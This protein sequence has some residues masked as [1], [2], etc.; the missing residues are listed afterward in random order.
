MPRWFLIAE[1]V[2]V[3]ALS[4][5]RS[6]VDAVVDLL[7]ALAKGPLGSQQA[8]LNSSQDSDPWFDLLQQLIGIAFTLVPVVL[9]VL[10]LTVSAGTL[11]RALGSLGLDGTRR[12]RDLVHGLL[13][14]ACIGL[15]GL[16]LYYAGRALG[17]TLEVI[18]AALD[19][20]WWTVPVLIL[21]AVKNAVVEEV[22]VVGYL[23]R[24]LEALGVGAAGVLAITAVL[25]ASYHLYQGIGPGLANM[26]MGLVFTQYFRRT[27]RVLPLVLAHTLLDVVAFVGY[28]L[29]KSVL[30]L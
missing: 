27:G 17:A 23:T 6:A 21:Q 4:L 1:I 2:V 10:L 25:R 3:L 11:S 29:L 22:I 26:V 12:L 20:H 30:P 24:R 14:A 13:L 15:P 9:V 16:A 19:A 8:T 5:G 28:A 7:R 18:P